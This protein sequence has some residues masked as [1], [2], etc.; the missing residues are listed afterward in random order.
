M[1]SLTDMVSIVTPVVLP[2]SDDAAE[3]IASIVH[4]VKCVESACSSGLA[5]LSVEFHAC[6]IFMRALE[7]LRACYI[8]H[9]PDP[10]SEIK[11]IIEDVK[12]KMKSPEQRILCDMV[13]QGRNYVFHGA[14]MHRTLALLQCTCAVAHILRF[15]ASNNALCAPSRSPKVRAADAVGSSD[16][17]ASSTTPKTPSANVSSSSNVECAAAD[18]C[19]ASVTLILQRVGISDLQSL[20]KETVSNHH[21]M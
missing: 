6:L 19:D 11:D 8:G 7:Q 9:M 20:I 18:A 1:Q 15:L 5:D 13:L 2:Q 16:S 12:K 3:A 21:D 14:D 10:D 4:H 17:R